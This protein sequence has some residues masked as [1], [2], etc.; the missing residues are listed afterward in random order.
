[1]RN[2]VGCQPYATISEE[3]KR[4]SQPSLFFIF[5][6][7]EMGEFD[8][9]ICNW[10][11][12]HAAIDKHLESERNFGVNDLSIKQHRDKAAAQKSWHNVMYIIQYKNGK[13]SVF[14]LRKKYSTMTIAN[15]SDSK[16]VI[17]A[18]SCYCIQQPIQ[19]YCL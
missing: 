6:I 2:Q 5:H 8:V 19:G 12:S 3:P 9:F 14:Y 7:A 10:V 17:K 1:M 18:N 13:T 15:D 4:T 11:N 16:H